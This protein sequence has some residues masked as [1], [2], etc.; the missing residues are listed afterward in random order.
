MMI[1]CITTHLL[2]S[3]SIYGEQPYT[4]SEFHFLTTFSEIS[5]FLSHLAK[6][7]PQMTPFIYLFLNRIHSK[8]KKR[9]SHLCFYIRDRVVLGGA[10]HP[11]N[12]TQLYAE[13]QSRRTWAG[14]PQFKGIQLN[15]HQFWQKKSDIYSTYSVGIY[16]KKNFRLNLNCTHVLGP[17]PRPSLLTYQSFELGQP[18]KLNHLCS[19][20]RLQSNQCVLTKTP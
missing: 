7:L 8:N 9:K 18:S 1:H 3:Q 16:L 5:V 15:T 4:Q 14:P 10:H 19:Q 11:K 20:P 13:R 17:S 12:L 6:L 2:K